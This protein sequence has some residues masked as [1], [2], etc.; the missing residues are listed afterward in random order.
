M[1]ETD[2]TLAYLAGFF[3]GEGCIYSSKTTK[4]AIPSLGLQVTNTHPDVIEQFKQRFGGFITKSVRETP[5]K[6]AY[7]WW[8]SGE[9]A[10]E[11]LI[12]LLPYL[13]V[14]KNQALLG[15]EMQ[16]YVV[17]RGLK[18][19]QEFKDR[20]FELSKRLAADKRINYA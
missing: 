20:R 19:P 17:R 11:A 3:D 2:V 9:K 10:S 12:E 7:I 8:L 5:R 18:L 14:K 16:S 15:I 6:T 4:K 1:K 13:V